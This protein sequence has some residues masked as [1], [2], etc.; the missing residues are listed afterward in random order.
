MER[1]ISY[2]IIKLDISY[3]DEIAVIE[4]ACFSVPWSPETIR[5]EMSN[6]INDFYGAVDDGGKLLG[7]IGYQNVCDEMNVFNVAVLPEARRNGI[8]NGL[9]GRMTEDARSRGTGVINLEVR[10]TNLSAIGLY[11]RNGFVFCGIRKD[12]YTDPRENAILMRLAFDGSQEMEDPVEI[13][14]ED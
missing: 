12:Y 10:A 6:C 2:K 13:W 9:V 1:K 8:G 14:D 11:E 7:Y 3:A 4:K 5:S